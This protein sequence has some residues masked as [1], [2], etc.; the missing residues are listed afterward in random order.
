MS[1]VSRPPSAFGPNRRR[2]TW[3]AFGLVLP[4]LIGFVAQTATLSVAL[5]QVVGF[6]LVLAVAS[7]RALA[8]QSASR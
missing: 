4:A 5:A 3:T 1:A 6:A 2:E 7:R 8:A